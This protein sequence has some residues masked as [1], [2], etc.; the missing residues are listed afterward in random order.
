MHNMPTVP[1]PG[2]YHHRQQQQKV[3]P[4]PP[5]PRYGPFDPSN[6][7]L[8][9]KKR[10]RFDANGY[11]IGSEIEQEAVYLPP[12]LQS[13]QLPQPQK[14]QSSKLWIIPVLFVLAPLA[15]PVLIVGL[16]VLGV[17]ASIV[18]QLWPVI[19]VILLALLLAYGLVRKRRRP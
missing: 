17:L 10:T 18:Q 5:P 2:G 11:P 16:M 7:Q 1:S 12:Y 15:L 14:T 13:Q 4:P 19:L 6:W 3:P 8:K 9:W